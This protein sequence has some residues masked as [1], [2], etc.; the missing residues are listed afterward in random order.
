VQRWT[1]N[2]FGLITEIDEWIGKLLDKM[3][4]LGIAENT[5]LAFSADH[6]EMLGS[7]GMREKN[8]FY[9]E[10]SRVPLLLR[11]P[12]TIPAG[13]TIEDPVSHLDL[14]STFLDFSVGRTDYKTD[15]MSLR[16]YVEGGPNSRDSFMV[17]MWNSTDITNDYRPSRDPAF[18]I[19]FDNWKLILSCLGSDHQLDM[20]FNLDEDPAELNNL[21]GLNGNTAPDSVIGK[22]E[23]LKAMLVKY[24]M[25]A[26]HPAATAVLERRTWKRLAFWVES[27]SIAFRDVLADGT[28]TEYLYLGTTAGE[29]IS[30]SL[31][32]G[33]GHFSIRFDSQYSRDEAGFTVVAVRFAKI[34]QSLP[35]ENSTLVVRLGTSEEKVV[36]LVPPENTIGFVDDDV[37]ADPSSD[38][39][40]FFDQLEFIAMDPDNS[41]T[42][43]PTSPPTS[44]PTRSLVPSSIPTSFLPCTDR[45]SELAPGDKLYSEQEPRVI[46]SPN[47]LYRFGMT[48]DGELAI[49]HLSE[50]IWSANTCCQG[51]GTYLNMQR[52]GNMVVYTISEGDDSED[53]YEMSIYSS[54]TYD[55][56]NAFLTLDDEGKAA[57]RSSNDPNNILWENSYNLFSAIN[58]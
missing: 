45:P 11:M 32:G 55:N 48:P 30:I 50:M 20:L 42:V 39:E 29:V 16:T 57:I 56:A 10:S 3:D 35:Q 14:H 15:G 17:T 43:V 49:W 9:E 5:L 4:E 54:E 34:Q 51:S 46:C 27:S 47:G 2:Y 23:H 28:R 22:A 38:G 58:G 36:T 13:V 25:D 1:A 33:N 26:N 37:I 44:Y 8:N 18:M 21:I 12:G 6:G 41:P 24:L 31:V 52:D 19:R 53:T 7:H 40:P